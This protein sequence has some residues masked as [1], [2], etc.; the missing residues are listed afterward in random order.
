[1]REKAR[2]SGTP[3]MNQVVV[4]SG[5]PITIA[6]PK[7]PFGFQVVADAV[8]TWT[9]VGGTTNTSVT[10]PAGMTIPGY[11]SAISVASGTIIVHFW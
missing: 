6:S 3:S 10:I 8:V 2:M 5:A 11:M 7:Y 9:G 4:T 1:M